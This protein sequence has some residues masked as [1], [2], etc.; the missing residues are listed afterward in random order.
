MT[1]DAT[2]LSAL[3]VSALLGAFWAVACR[4]YLMH[5]TETRPAVAAAHFALGV[6][7]ASALF[8]PGKWGDAG[9]AMGVL[10]FLLAGSHRWRDGAPEG[11]RRPQSLPCTPADN[12]ERSI[13]P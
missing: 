4:L 11:T 9:L 3:T 7:V 10:M 5:P 12:A 1:I 13:Q 8:L 2:V 6:G